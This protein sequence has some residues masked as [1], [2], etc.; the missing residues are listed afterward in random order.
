M[1]LAAVLEGFR[2]DKCGRPYGYAKLA[3]EFEM[4][5]D[6]SVVAEGASL[7]ISVTDAMQACFYKP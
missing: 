5:L 6:Q 2:V 7:F 1:S 4:N 3:K